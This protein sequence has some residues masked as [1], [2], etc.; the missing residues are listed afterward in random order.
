MKAL[1]ISLI[2]IAIIAVGSLSLI[3][4][5]NLDARNLENDVK[6]IE[7]Q[8]NI[9]PIERAEMIQ[10]PQTTITKLDDKSRVKTTTTTLSVPENNTFPFG[11]IKGNVVNPTEGHPVILQIYKYLEEGPIHIAQV[12]L[13]EDNTFEYSF[14]V[15]SI[16]DGITTH[17]YE[18]DYF[19]K[20]IKV[21]NT[22]TIGQIK[23]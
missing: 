20:V 22:P 8:D 14:R 1:T 17:F 13:K 6:K 7:I 18:G 15:L 5:I 10:Y 21:I 16:D 12:N 4:A 11:F 23:N 9:S 19:V 2:M 3:M